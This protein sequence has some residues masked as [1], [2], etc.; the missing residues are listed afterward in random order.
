MNWYKVRIKDGSER[1]YTYVGSS[2]DSLETIAAKAAAG[3]FIR[4]HDLLYYDRGEVKT[5]AEWDAREESTVL[6]NATCII[7]IQ[8]FKADPRTIAK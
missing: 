6:I 3:D 4:L 2:P 1:G 7:A 8:P 5:W